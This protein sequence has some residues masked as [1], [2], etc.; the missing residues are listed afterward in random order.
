[1]PGQCRVPVSE[2][3]KELARG[4]RDYYGDVDN[5]KLNNNIVGW[6]VKT[7]GVILHKQHNVQAYQ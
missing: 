3:V 4:G 7:M 6:G 2:E 1:M 5:S